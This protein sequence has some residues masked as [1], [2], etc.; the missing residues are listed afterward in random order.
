ML[1][2]EIKIEVA[3]SKNLHLLWIKNVV[4]FLMSDISLWRSFKI[5]LY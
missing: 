2:K 3:P 4:V 1:A 5:W